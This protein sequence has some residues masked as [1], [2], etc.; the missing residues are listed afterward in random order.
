M[1]SESVV[2]GSKS[3]GNLDGGMLIGGA[4]VVVS[5]SSGVMLVI[6]PAQYISG[7]FVVLLEV[8]VSHQPLSCKAVKMIS[9]EETSN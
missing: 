6:G 8:I 5:K 1:V 7:W 3:S 9:Q 2:S 4:V